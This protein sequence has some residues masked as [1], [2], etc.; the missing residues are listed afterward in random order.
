[1]DFRVIL[2]GSSVNLG[3]YWG[4]LNW[5]I[6]RSLLASTRLSLPWNSFLT[7]DLPYLALSDSGLLFLASSGFI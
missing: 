1:M 5:K 7:I 2:Y 3:G 6:F 4:T